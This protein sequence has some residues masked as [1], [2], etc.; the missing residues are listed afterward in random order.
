MDQ[1]EGTITTSS[2]S[3]EI[4]D[5]DNAKESHSTIRSIID[6]IS[7]DGDLNTFIPN[8]DHSSSQLKSSGAKTSKS[9]SS[10]STIENLFTG[11]IHHISS[12]RG[13]LYQLATGQTGFGSF[14]DDEYF[15]NEV[16]RNLN[17]DSDLEGKC[18]VFMNR[19]SAEKSYWSYRWCH[20]IG[21]DQF[22]VNDG[23][24]NIK[25]SILKSSYIYYN[26]GT[27]KGKHWSGSDMYDAGDS[28]Q[29]DKKSSTPRQRSST[30]IYE[31]CSNHYDDN[32]ILNHKD[33]SQNLY[34][35]SNDKKSNSIYIRSVQEN[36]ICEYEIYVCRPSICLKDEYNAGNLTALNTMKNH[37]PLFPPMPEEQIGKNKELIK[38]MFGHAY[39][40]YMYNA[41]PAAE[42]R[43]LT[44]KGG[45]F[46]LVR[47]KCVTLIDTLDAI[48][49]F[50]N[51]TEFARSVERLKHQDKIERL[52]K[53][54]YK[55]GLFDV[56]EDVSVFE[57][58]IRILGGLLSAHQMALAFITENDNLHI[59][60][61]DVLDENGGVLIGPLKRNI[62]S[63]SSDKHWEYD[64]FLLKL[65]DDLGKRLL[66]AFSSKSGIPYGTVNLRHGV[67]KG[68]TPV[69]SLAGA[70]T[71]TLE[72]EMLSRLTG[73]PSV[74]FYHLV[75]NF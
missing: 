51:F 2:S 65:A 41:F 14:H 19:Q 22:H 45:K 58:N 32:D 68:E 53:T 29:T 21:I 4:F 57:T 25:D 39:D 35:S 27:Y 73:N 38:K 36:N 34:K 15:M 11:N 52:S 17:Q 37:A 47:L 44:C 7:S 26:L 23:Q 55:G 62:N 70:G 9:T 49:I 69:A 67:P 10:S 60:L 74:S 6:M 33:S 72:M 40:S 75:I 5:K 24:K 59:P 20:G 63:P 31:C 30:V 71:L 43:P 50:G 42:L 28:C 3:Y 13:D 56:N 8:T 66:P 1:H 54:K 12:K 61:S 46:E 64:G 16:N 18:D 48:L